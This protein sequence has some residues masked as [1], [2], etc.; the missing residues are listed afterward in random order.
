MHP[1]KANI[2]QISVDAS[3]MITK[4]NWLHV[5]VPQWALQSPD[6]NLV[7]HLWE[8]IVEQKVHSMNVQLTN[9]QQ[10]HDAIMSRW[11]RISEECFQPLI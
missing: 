2:Y 11:T 5:G 7:E 3:N 8:N 1:F 6:L 10:L 9:L 4:Y